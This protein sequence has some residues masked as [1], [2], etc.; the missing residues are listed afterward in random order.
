MRNELFDV[1][2]SPDRVPILLKFSIT[3]FKFGN[4]TNIIEDTQEIPQSRG[5]AFPMYQKNKDEEQIITKQ[6]YKQATHKRI[7]ATEEPPWNGNGIE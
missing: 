4:K 1:V 2:S 5:N 6:T 7:T 3:S